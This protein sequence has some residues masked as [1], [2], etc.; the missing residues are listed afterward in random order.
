MSAW[1]SVPGKVASSHLTHRRCRPASS[2]LFFFGRLLAPCCL[3]MPWRFAE[4]SA[5]GVAFV[6]SLGDVGL[7][8]VPA[9]SARHTGWS[10]DQGQGHVRFA[11]PAR[12]AFRAGKPRGPERG[13]VPWRLRARPVTVR[14]QRGSGS[15]A[16]KWLR[17]SQGRLRVARNGFESPRPAR[18]VSPATGSRPPEGGRSR[19]AQRRTLR[20]SRQL[21]PRVC[22]CS[23]DMYE[24]GP[25]DDE[26]TLTGY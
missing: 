4:P 25:L 1:R 18:T 23:P 26:P 22:S 19:R 9:R 12:G 6:G 2:W 8:D 21:Q 15:R 16:S 13:I 7:L 24:S 11:A 10:G 5:R 20:G 17:V 3:A 14:C